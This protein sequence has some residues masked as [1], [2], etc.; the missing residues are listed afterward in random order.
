MDGCKR[1]RRIHVARET[2][3]QL[4]GFVEA[5]LPDTQISQPGQRATAQRAVTK[6]SQA[7]GLGQC[8]IGFEPASS[9]RQDTAV[10]GA[11]ERRDSR[12]ASPF[13][14]R[15]PDTDPLIGARHVVRVLAGRE[16][17]AEDLLQNAEVVDIA[18]G[19][20]GERL[21]EEHHAFFRPVGTHEARAEVRERHELEVAVAKAACE[22]ERLSKALLLSTRS[23]SNML[24]SATYPTSEDSGSSASNVCAR[25]I[26][27]LMTAPS[28]KIDRY[29][30]VP[31][32]PTP[33]GGPSRTG[34]PDHPCRFLS[35]GVAQRSS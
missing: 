22:L 4:L 17:L 8:A 15:L 32:G 1:A 14:N 20:R 16:E 5:P 10:V 26:Q 19:H 35:G 28:P 11:A 25:A 30:N 6:T 31:T 33:T 34:P 23:P 2:V 12:K 27:P 13:R 29:P 21:V 18:A 3:E 24:F 9:G 7:D